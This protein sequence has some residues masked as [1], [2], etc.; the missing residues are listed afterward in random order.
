MITIDTNSVAPGKRASFW[1]ESF[2]DFRKSAI[3]VERSDAARFQG[4]VRVAA[5]G[6]LRLVEV[7]AS[8]HRATFLPIAE[9]SVSVHV[10]L[11]GRALV[12]QGRRHTAPIACLILRESSDAER[13]TIG[14]A[15][16]AS[17]SFDNPLIPSMPGRFRSRSIREKSEPAAIS[18]SA[19]SQVL[20]SFVCTVAP[21]S[22]ITP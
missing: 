6:G 9:D 19:S 14:V 13:T 12:E 16:V 1:Q 10:H 2:L 11:E 5:L 8:P 22:S 7:I 20:A 18:A 15:G 4:H 21:S 3:V 17:R